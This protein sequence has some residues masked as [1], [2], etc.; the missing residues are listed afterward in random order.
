MRREEDDEE[1]EEEDDEEE[2]DGSERLVDYVQNILLYLE[3]NE[4]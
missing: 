3:R 1:E 2:E 4:L